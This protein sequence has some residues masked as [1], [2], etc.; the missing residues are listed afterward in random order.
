MVT[1]H[2][3]DTARAFAPWPVSPVSSSPVT[4]TTSHSVV[5]AA[6][7]FFEDGDYALYRD[8]LSANCRA[9][10]VEVWAWYLMPNHVQLILEL[11]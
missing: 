6:R 11:R 5:M 9:A 3:I 7:T 10:D 8:L 4:R 1:V 2:L